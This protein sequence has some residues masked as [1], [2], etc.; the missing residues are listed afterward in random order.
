MIYLYLINYSENNP[1]LAII[2]INSFSK[3]CDESKPS[4]IRGLALRS[5]CSLR[6][7]GAYDF[8]KPIVLEMLQDKDPYVKKTAINGCLKL[9]YLNPDFI[10]GRKVSF[11]K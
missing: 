11:R 9:S 3:D 10:D 7:E 4:T 2:A 1:D 6:F 8:I 5:L